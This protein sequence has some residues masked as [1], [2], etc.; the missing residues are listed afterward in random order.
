LYGESSGEE[1]RGRK[2]EINK[3]VNPALVFK[4]NNSNMEAALQEKLTRGLFAL[5]TKSRSY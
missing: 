3:H 2:R 5:A 1:R 4:E